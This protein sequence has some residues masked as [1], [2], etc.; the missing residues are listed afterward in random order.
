MAKDISCFPSRDRSDAARVG[1]RPELTDQLVQA[2]RIQNR[3]QSFLFQVLS[4][5]ILRSGLYR[6]KYFGLIHFAFLSFKQLPG[7]SR[8][9]AHNEIKIAF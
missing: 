6:H 9:K 8:D 3:R 7:R 1:C 4:W 2:H 5:P